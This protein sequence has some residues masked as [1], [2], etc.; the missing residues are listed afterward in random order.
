MRLLEER[1]VEISGIFCT[2]EEPIFLGLRL[3]LIQ[4]HTVFSDRCVKEYGQ[5]N[6]LR[7]ISWH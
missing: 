2:F 5:F 6:A 7:L 1:N 4:L 3:T